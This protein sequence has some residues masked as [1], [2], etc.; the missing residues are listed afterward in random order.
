MINF[1]DLATFSS[2]MEMR[3]LLLILSCRAER[4]VF[5]AEWY[6]DVLLEVV[7]EV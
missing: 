1:S 3:E 2:L 7:L 5:D 4:N 6:E